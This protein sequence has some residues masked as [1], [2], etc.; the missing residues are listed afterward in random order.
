MADARG[1]R[2]I[3]TPRLELVSLTAR[4]VEAI[5][6]AD[7]GR[8]EAEIGARVGRS[9]AADPGHFVQLHLAQRTAEVDGFEGIGR[10]IVLSVRGRARRVIGSIGFQG[11]PDDQGRLVLGCQVSR[12]HRGRGYGAEA[13]CAL[14]EWATDRFGV[15]RFLVAVPSQAEASRLVPV[16]MWERGGNVPDEWMA[17]LASIPERGPSQ[18][19]VLDL[20]ERRGT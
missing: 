14:T 16:E 7:M 15:T 2:T 1:V 6:A 12:A 19:S 4:F 17:G 13:M 5:V 9:L 8:A 20:S 10:A 11:L 18:N 3:R